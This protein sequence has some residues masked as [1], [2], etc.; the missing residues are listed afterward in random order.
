[1]GKEQS[2]TPVF[3]DKMAYLELNPAWNLPDS[4]IKEEIL[5]AMAKNPGYLA[6]H[7]MEVVADVATSGS[8][9]GPARTTRS[10]R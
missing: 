3:S 8:A 4:I 9:S 2:R 1:M 10:A 5:P 7:N 6:S